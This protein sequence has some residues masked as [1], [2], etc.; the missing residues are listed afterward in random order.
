MRINADALE[1][2][3]IH[4]SREGPDRLRTVLMIPS[5]ISI[6]GSR[7]GPDEK[8]HYGEDYTVMLYK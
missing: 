7:E 2:I 6:H 5:T 8:I 3:S 1:I 4:G